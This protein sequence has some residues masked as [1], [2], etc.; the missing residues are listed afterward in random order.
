MRNR[1]YC[2]TR[3]GR[4]PGG[5]TPKRVGQNLA[6]RLRDF[7]PNVL[8]LLFDLS[9][10]FTN[11]LGEQDVRMTKVKQKIS[12]CFRSDAEVVDFVVIRTHHD[13]P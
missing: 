10:P 11:N 4:P 7:K 3:Q 9:V 1:R 8:P 12:G 2:L 6:L 13:R 5:A